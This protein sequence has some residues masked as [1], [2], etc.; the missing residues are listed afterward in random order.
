[1]RTFA[2]FGVAAIAISIMSPNLV[3]AWSSE[4]AIPQG[5]D[6]ANLSDPTIS[7]DK[8]KALQDKVSGGSSSTSGFYIT[9]GA[10]EQFDKPGFQT[11][12]GPAPFGYSP[13]P[14]F[15]GR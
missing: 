11:N 15:R 8:L 9:G 10:T 4:Q 5:A 1:M 13:L 7:E 12:S 14:G 6:G 2:L 3:W